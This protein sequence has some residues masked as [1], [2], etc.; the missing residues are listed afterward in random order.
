MHG[1]IFETSIWL[2]AGSTRELRA[3]GHSLD[4]SRDDPCAHP[5]FARGARTRALSALFSILTKHA[6]ARD[7]EHHT[8][9]S[10]LPPVLCGTGRRHSIYFHHFA[11]LRLTSRINNMCFA[12][13][14]L[15]YFI[16]NLTLDRQS[17]RHAMVYFVVLSEHVVRPHVAG[18]HF[19]TAYVSER[20]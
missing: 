3:F 19:V 17:S 15:L 14:I 6:C 16:L 11:F 2:L 7:R 8:T 20:S 10:L 12:I 4:H 5:S 13:L 1:L 18:P 9:V